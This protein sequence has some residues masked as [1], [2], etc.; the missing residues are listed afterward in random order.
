MADICFTMV[1]EKVL[2]KEF[3]EYHTDKDNFSIVSQKG[4][5]GSFNVIKKIIDY[6][7]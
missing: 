6:F 3:K 7:V 2:M 1:I 5:E 4:L